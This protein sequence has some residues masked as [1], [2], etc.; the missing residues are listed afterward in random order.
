MARRSSITTTIFIAA[1]G[2]HWRNAAVEK[3]MFD[4]TRFWYKRGVAG[5]RLDAVDTMYEREDLKD[6]RRRRNGQVRPA[7]YRRNTTR[8]Y[9]KFTPRCA[10]FEKSQML[11][12]V[13]IGRPDQRYIAIERLLQRTQRRTATAHGPAV[14]RVAFSPD[15]YRK[16]VA[17]MILPA[18]AGVRDQQSRYDAILHALRG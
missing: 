3:A 12:R 5:F 8:S 17:A 13:L 18:L 1:A 4:T 7:E 9:L 15:A 14:E 11:T 2:P 10:V 6:N 16:H